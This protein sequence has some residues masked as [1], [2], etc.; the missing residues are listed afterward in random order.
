MEQPRSIHLSSKA[1][2]SVQAY[3]ALFAQSGSQT[4]RPLNDLVRMKNMIEHSNILVTAWSN[5]RLVG[6]ARGVSDYARVCYLNDVLVARDVEPCTLEENLL[7]HVA[8]LVGSDC[9]IFRHEELGDMLS[10]NGSALLHH[11]ERHTA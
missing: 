10:T 4:T 8:Q 9:H 7:Q 5:Q 2:I 6:L 1:V 11:Q 3:R